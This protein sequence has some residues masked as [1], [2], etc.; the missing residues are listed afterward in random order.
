MPGQVLH[1]KPGLEARKRAVAAGQA[2]SYLGPTANN[3][4]QCVPM[5]LGVPITIAHTT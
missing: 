1:L 5:I 2:P 4:K 3:K